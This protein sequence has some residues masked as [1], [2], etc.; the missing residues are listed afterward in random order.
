M[1]P[2]TQL[3]VNKANDHNMLIHISDIKIIRDNSTSSDGATSNIEENILW[4]NNTSRFL[5]VC[6]IGDVG[7]VI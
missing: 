7:D 6:F 1:N 4:T 5:L 3:W 2:N